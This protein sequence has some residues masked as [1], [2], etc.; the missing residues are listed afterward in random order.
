[1]QGW[2]KHCPGPVKSVMP[3]EVF[4]VMVIVYS[5]IDNDVESQGVPVSR[6]F[7]VA[8]KRINGEELKVPVMNVLVSPEQQP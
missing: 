7:S 3:F 8:V 4:D 1:M 5:V 2:P 6:Y